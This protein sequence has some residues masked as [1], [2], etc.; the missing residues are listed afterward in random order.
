[1]KAMARPS[2]RV[3]EDSVLALLADS[4][5]QPV[6]RWGL[7]RAAVLGACYHADELFFGID[8]ERRDLIDRAVELTVDLPHA[9]EYG[10]FFRALEWES[11]NLPGW[12]AWVGKLI[13][14]G[15][16]TA[17]CNRLG[18]LEVDSAEVN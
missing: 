10:E 2:R 9:E 8:G 3:V 1:M 4:A 7:V 14:V 15:P 13:W 5:I 6:H 16:R 17:H 18:L 12:R 11:S